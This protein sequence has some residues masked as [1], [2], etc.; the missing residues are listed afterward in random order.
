MVLILSVPLEKLVISVKM[1]NVVVKYA[2]NKA[3]DATNALVSISFNFFKVYIKLNIIISFLNKDPCPFQYPPPSNCQNGYQAYNSPEGCAH[4]VCNE[5][6]DEI[7]AADDAN[8]ATA[9]AAL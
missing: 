3:T 1:G 7:K 2:V 8:V 5:N 6:F 4:F 9:L